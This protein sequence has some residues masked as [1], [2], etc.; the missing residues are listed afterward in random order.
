MGRLAAANIP[1]RDE[2]GFG[3]AGGSG[4]GRR[5]EAKRAQSFSS[6]SHFPR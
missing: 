1:T 3:Q 5:E 6:C 2:E 4:S